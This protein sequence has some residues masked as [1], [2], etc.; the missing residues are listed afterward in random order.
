MK[1]RRLLIVPKSSPVRTKYNQGVH[2]E[3]R[4]AFEPAVACGNIAFRYRRSILARRHHSADNAGSLRKGSRVLLR[5]SHARQY[6]VQEAWEM[7]EVQNDVG[8]EAS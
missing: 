7:S 2:D 5:L 8:E 6:Q 3:F 1:F 4:K